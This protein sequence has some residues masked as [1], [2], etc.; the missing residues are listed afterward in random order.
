M[1]IARKFLAYVLFSFLA[2]CALANKA[3]NCHDGEQC[4][5][6]TEDE[7]AMLQL[8]RAEEV[9]QDQQK[10]IASLAKVS[11]EEFQSPSSPK[12]DGQTDSIASWATFNS[13]DQDNDGKITTKELNI[14]LR[15][16]AEIQELFNFEYYKDSGKGKGKRGPPPL[17]KVFETLIAKVDNNGDGMISWPE[18]SE[19]FQAQK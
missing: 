17:P 3:G 14:S 4:T 2:A 12:V 9:Q 6:A 15:E 16:S 19:Y 10:Q 11:F 7:T 13:I 18:F 8:S 1:A 5:Q